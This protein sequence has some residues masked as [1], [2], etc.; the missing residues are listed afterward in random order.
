[1]NDLFYVRLCDVY[2]KGLV[3]VAGEWIELLKDGGELLICSSMDLENDALD[4]DSR[5]Q[6]SMT[7]S[8]AKV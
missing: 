6:L 8:I 7:K 1:M 5:E 4:N 2:S 3:N